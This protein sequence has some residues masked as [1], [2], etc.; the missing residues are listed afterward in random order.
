M[1]IKTFISSF[2]ALS[3]CSLLY[4]GQNEHKDIL[5]QIKKGV[6]E[7]VQDKMPKNTLQDLITAMAEACYNGDEDISEVKKIMQK[8]DLNA[9]DYSQALYECAQIEYECFPIQEKIATVLIE[10]GA[11]VNAFRYYRVSTLSEAILARNLELVKFLVKNGAYVNE[12]GKDKLIY[13]NYLLASAAFRYREDILTF[14]IDNG[15]DVNLTVNGDN[16]LDTLMH[17]FSPRKK[18]AALLIK[19]GVQITDRVFNY[20]KENDMGYNGYGGV[21]GTYKYLKEEQEKQQRRNR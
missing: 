8:E 15:A 21:P 16:S 1:K 12:E 11:D 20:V 6:F 7:S 10:N 14:L 5:T 3:L 13:N 2:I 17:Y 18:A 19:H 4:A 9:D